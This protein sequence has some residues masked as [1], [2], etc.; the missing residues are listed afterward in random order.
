LVAAHRLRAL[1][2][3]TGA[4][5]WAVAR[6]DVLC[7]VFRATAESENAGSAAA[8]TTIAAANALH[9]ARFLTG[10]TGATITT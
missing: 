2:A 9:P 3:T 1:D 5:V 7:G 4:D 6:R 8:A 10:A